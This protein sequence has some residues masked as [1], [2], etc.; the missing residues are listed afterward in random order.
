M[1]LGS[2]PPRSSE[3]G[4]LR[5]AAT[6]ELTS[7]KK[8]FTGVVSGVRMGNTIKRGL[9]SRTSPMVAKLIWLKVRIGSEM[10]SEA[11]RVQYIHEQKRTLQQI[12]ELHIKTQVSSNEQLQATAFTQQGDVAFYTEDM[13]KVRAA[14]RRDPI[15]VKELDV[16]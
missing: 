14:L 5:G 16:W 13:L 3:G 7:L 4:A 8:V 11:Q 15:V 6:L 9:R 2:A 10:M 1:R 12:D